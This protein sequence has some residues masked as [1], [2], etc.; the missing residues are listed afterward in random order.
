MKRKA[1]LVASIAILAIVII[2]GA[3]LYAVYLRPT[4]GKLRVGY[5][6]ADLHHLA[7]FVAMDKGF[8]AD[9]GLDIEY[10]AYPHGVAVMDAFK[11]VA[12]DIGMLGTAP[13]TFKHIREGI[14]ITVIAFCN[15]EGSRLVARPGILRVEDLKGKRVAVHHVMSIQGVLLHIILGKH[16]L[17]YADLHDGWPVIMGAPLQPRALEAGEIDAFITWE[18][19]CS[20][21]IV[22]GYGV[23]LANSRDIWPFH[24]CCLVAVRTEFLRESPDSVKRFVRAHVRATRWIL[25]NPME[26]V[27]VA[28]KWTKLSKEV[29]MKAFEVC[30]FIYEP[31]LE[32]LKQ[33]IHYLLE[34]GYLK[35]EEVPDVDKFIGKFVDMTIMRDVLKELRV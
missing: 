23:A 27:E 1:L 2:A 3:A 11:A 28:V 7:F 21:A 10:V 4:P 16:G 14:D 22:E 13:A 20:K 12:I 34:F 26:A 19:F 8:Y 5:L 24:P 17:T 29:V 33:W 15:M 9:E 18:P 32:G 31:P 30:Y 25:E 6:T 35:P